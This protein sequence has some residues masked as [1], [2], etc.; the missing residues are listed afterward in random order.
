MRTHLRC[1]VES[2]SAQDGGGHHGQ[3]TATVRPDGPTHP[4]DGS[5]GGSGPV[6]E[7]ETAESPV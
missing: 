7:Q 6:A 3:S 5:E 2:E 4:D 1:C